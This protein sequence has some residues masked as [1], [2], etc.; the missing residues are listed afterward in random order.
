M[1]IHISL[2]VKFC[3]IYKNEHILIQ[4]DNFLHFNFYNKFITTNT[5]DIIF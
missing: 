4:Q 3:F 2:I 5:I 1:I